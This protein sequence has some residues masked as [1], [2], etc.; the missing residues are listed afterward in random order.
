MKTPKMIIFDY[1]QTL[2]DGISFNGLEGTKAILSEAAENT[3]VSAEAIQELADELNSEIRKYDPDVEKQPL[4][5]VHFQIFQNYL[6]EYFNIKLTKSPEETERIF[7]DA[8]FRAKPTK[9]IAVLLEYL[10]RKKI[11]TAVLSNTSSSTR[12][13]TERINKY[14][15]DNNFE[16]VIAS[17]EY[18]FRKPHGRIFE[19]ALRKARLDPCDVWYCGDSAFYDID[20]SAG[21]GITPVWYKGALEETNILTPSKDCIEIYD[22]NELIDILDAVSSY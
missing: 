12:I 10:G 21:C 6:Y 3:D 15:P 18:I 7:I 20:G 5:E 13:I 1:G 8:A 17:S 14:I 19:M 22:W 4:L 9:N 16:F 2:V 11:R